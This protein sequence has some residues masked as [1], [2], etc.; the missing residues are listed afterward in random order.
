MRWTVSVEN[1]KLSAHLAR[2]IKNP[3]QVEIL[4]EMVAEWLKAQADKFVY[5][6]DDDPCHCGEDC[7]DSHRAQKAIEVLA[8]NVAAD[9]VPVSHRTGECRDDDE[10]DDDNDDEEED[11]E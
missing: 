4:T 9:E 8:A 7:S 2:E 11:D 10:D 3:D 1:R 6:D 5:F